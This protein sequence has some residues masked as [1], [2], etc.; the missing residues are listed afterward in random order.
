LFHYYLNFNSLKSASKI[1]SVSNFSSIEIKKHFFLKEK[2]FVI[3]NGVNLKKF[4]PLNK[5]GNF[6]LFVGRLSERKGIFTFLKTAKKIDFDFAIVGTGEL[7][8]KVKKFIKKHN[9]SSK[10][11]F[12][13]FLEG[14]NLVRALQESLFIVLPS[15]YEGFPLVA[16]EAFACGKTV[17]ASNTGGIPEI[18]LNNK[19]GLLFKPGNHEHCIEKVKLLLENDSLR[20][21]LEKN[22]FKMVQ[23]F[24]WKNCAEKHLSLY[25]TLI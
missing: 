5:K 7:E 1:I 8:K 3:Y 4:F 12:L 13:G 14:K 18:V 10:V 23:N 22:A 2:P 24:S 15:L 16:L 20:K 21:K 11:K 25:K 19:T 17:I 6:I 9:L